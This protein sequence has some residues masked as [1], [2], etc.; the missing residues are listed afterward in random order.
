MIAATASGEPAS[1]C[2]DRLPIV[3]GSELYEL[4][5]CANVD[6]LAGSTPLAH[7]VIV[8][9]GSDRNAGEYFDYA[10]GAAE[11]A[12]VEAQTIVLAPQF[13][14]EE[15]LLT[16]AEPDDL[17]FWTSGG[18]KR[19]S[20]S[21]STA[22]NPRS[23]DI[24]SFAALEQLVSALAGLAPEL[25]SIVFVGHSAGGQFV[26]RFAAGNDLHSALPALDLSYVVA[27]PSSYMYLSPE[28]FVA[29]SPD[30]FDIPTAS[31]C[32]TWY[33][34][35]KFGLQDLDPYMAAVGAGE[36]TAR[37]A[38][39]NVIYLLGEEDDDPS[40]PYLDVSCAAMHQGAHRLERG[41]LFYQHLLD[42]FG[43]GI[44]STHEGAVVAG[45]DHNPYYMLRSD[46]ALAHLFGREELAAE[47][48]S[49]EE[50]PLPTAAPEILDSGLMYEGAYPNPFNPRTTLSFST[51]RPSPLSIRIH[52]ARGRLVHEA[53]V[54]P[55]S[56][57]VTTHV[58]DGL[59]LR[60]DAVASGVYRIV[61]RQGAESSTG[62][63]VLVR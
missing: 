55:S 50:L 49:L 20:Q 31:E 6:L 28:R 56:G 7:A 11:R 25:E 53:T 14:T 17:V 61:V 58:W 48:L 51:D 24:S 60:G 29:G 42:R 45:V 52:D 23:E 18:W 46:C 19:G 36:L 5:Y 26:Q 57:A 62:S 1:V 13:L 9:H 21:L 38:A 35:Y 41:L 12:G 2:V 27:N 34:D 30:L 40:S 16:Q 39:R 37:Y 33:D 32:P 4:P 54:T 15:E 22:A 59:D 47:C 8:I 43:S 63:L 44:R 3:V 10:Y